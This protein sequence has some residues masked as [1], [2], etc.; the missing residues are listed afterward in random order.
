MEVTNIRL[1]K[2]ELERLCRELDMNTDQVLRSIAFQVEGEAKNKAP[3]D[4]GALKNSLHTEH[5]GKNKYLVADAVEYG[6]Y[7]ELGTHKMA[8]QPFLVPAV[9][10]VR[11]YLADRFKGLFT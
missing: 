3:V 4:T 2:R 11:K 6:I 9:E 1:D 8:A 5:K 10:S 7:Q